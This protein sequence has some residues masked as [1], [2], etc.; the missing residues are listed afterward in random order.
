[1]HALQLTGAPGREVIGWFL[2]GCLFCFAGTKQAYCV[3][4]IYAGGDQSFAHYDSADLYNNFTVVGSSSLYIY[5]CHRPY[6]LYKHVCIFSWILGPQEP[7][8][9]EDKEW[10]YDNLHTDSSA[11]RQMAE[12]VTWKTPSGNLQ[13]R[14][15]SNRP[16]LFYSNNVTN[17]VYVAPF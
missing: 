2:W 17:C 14:A 8:Q 15:R 9:W 3:K 6:R 10:E 4:R 12:P 13:V 11:N 5:M 1:M 7:R 16:H